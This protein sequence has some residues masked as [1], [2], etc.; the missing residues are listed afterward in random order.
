[1]KILFEAKTNTIA[2]EQTSSS[3]T[4]SISLP[5]SLSSFF[6][7]FLFLQTKLLLIRKNSRLNIDLMTNPATIDQ[8]YNQPKKL[9]LQNNTYQGHNWLALVRSDHNRLINWQNHHHHHNDDGDDDNNHDFDKNY[10]HQ[11]MN[12]DDYDYNNNDADVDDDDD[13]ND[14][15][16]INVVSN[17]PIAQP[18]PNRYPYYEV[19]QRIEKNLHSN[20]NYHNQQQQESLKNQIKNSKS[21]K[22]SSLI[23]DHHDVILSLGNQRTKSYNEYGDSSSNP[24]NVISNILSKKLPKSLST[25][26][27]IDNE[28]DVSISSSSLSNVDTSHLRN[29]RH[30]I[31]HSH[32]KNHHHHHEQQHDLPT[33]HHH[34]K[35]ETSDISSEDS[36]KN[37]TDIFKH[38][39]EMESRVYRLHNR[40]S[41]GD[42]SYN[43]QTNTIL[44]QWNTDP[45]ISDTHLTFI[46][47]KYYGFSIYWPRQQK[48]LC[49]N[50]NTSQIIAK[51]CFDWCLCSFNESFDGDHLMYELAMNPD[52]KLA[53]N[54]V[55]QPVAFIYA[56]DGICNDWEKSGEEIF[57]KAI[58]RDPRLSCILTHHPQYSRLASKK[59]SESKLKRIKLN[60]NQTDNDNNNNYNNNDNITEMALPKSNRCFNISS[61]LFDSSYHQSNNHNGQTMPW[62]RIRRLAKKVKH[63]CG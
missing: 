56:E 55:G 48:F 45:T 35:Q 63:L 57:D 3:S 41:K 36:N 22:L 32:D 40:C 27:R 17:Q 11:L 28:S 7:T 37:H 9:L 50:P 5:S 58:H 15:Q 43:N 51:D 49:I 62:K 60:I 1:M 42:L 59:K 31:H 39:L 46:P 47:S 21:I 14:G 25:E 61:L 44:S 26:S 24:E 10:N 54:K 30:V 53:F 29:K 4:P 6:S 8:Y 16:I 13:D 33:H 2:I 18:R 20:H 23:N 34:H 12:D 19:R 38:S 52:W